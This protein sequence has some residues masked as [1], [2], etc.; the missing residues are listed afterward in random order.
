[1]VLFLGLAQWSTASKLITVDVEKTQVKNAKS[2]IE[3]IGLSKIS[4][5]VEFPNPMKL[6]GNTTFPVDLI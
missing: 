1:M 4:E 6:I 2:P 5:F 3:R